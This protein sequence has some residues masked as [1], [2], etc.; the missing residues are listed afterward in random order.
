VL[1]YAASIELLLLFYLSIAM[2]IGAVES[3]VVVSFGVSENYTHLKSG[4]LESRLTDS[5]MMG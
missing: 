4:F 3:I 1:L 5:R 2:V